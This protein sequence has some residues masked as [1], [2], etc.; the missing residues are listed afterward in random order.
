[1]NSVDRS[2]DQTL[3]NNMGD[4]LKG[5]NEGVLDETAKEDVLFF[6]EKLANSNIAAFDKFRTSS[7]QA[8]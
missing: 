7:T 2:F 8:L 3:K 4:D 1:M 5:S 6:V